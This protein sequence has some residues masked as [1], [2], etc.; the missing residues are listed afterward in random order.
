[1]SIVALLWFML[2]GVAMTAPAYGQKALQP[3]PLKGE[4]AQIDRWFAKASAEFDVPVSVL[5]S[6]G[7]AESRWKQ[8][9]PDG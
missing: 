6:I 9:I 5:Q 3:G 1:M 7:Y 2:V 4:A 8:I